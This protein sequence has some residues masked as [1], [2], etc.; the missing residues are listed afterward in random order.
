VLVEGRLYLET[1]APETVKTHN[2]AHNRQVV[3]HLDGLD[4]TVIIRGVATPNAPSKLVGELVAAEFSRKYAGYA[5]ERDRR[6]HGGL[7][8][9]EPDAVLAWTDMPTVTRWRFAR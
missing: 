7:V 2:L 5:P 3:V 4:D 1:G 9:V 8:L 6:E